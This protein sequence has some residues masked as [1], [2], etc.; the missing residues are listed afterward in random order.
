MPKKMVWV[1][2]G[3]PVL[4]SLL[5]LGACDDI[6]D[7]GV[8]G[9]EEITRPAMSVTEA[10]SIRHEEAEFFA[11]AEEIPG[12]GGY[13]F[14]E[15]GNLIAHIKDKTK[16]KED[17]AKKLLDSAL[18]KHSHALKQ[19]HGKVKIKTGEYAFPELA[20]WRDQLSEQLLGAGL[21]AHSTDADEGLNR[22]VVEVVSS[23]VR[24]TVRRKIAELGIPEGAVLVVEVDATGVEE[25]WVASRDSRPGYSHSDNTYAALRGG[26]PLYF[27]RDARLSYCTL[28]FFAKRS[29]GTL[30][31]VT[32]S[33]CSRDQW[34]G[35][36]DGTGYYADLDSNS[37]TGVTT[38]SSLVAW[39]IHDRGF[40]D[41]CPKLYNAIRW[42]RN[43]DANLSEVYSE[44]P[45]T[46]F[47]YIVR[48]ARIN[49][50][51]SDNSYYL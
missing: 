22:V 2:F 14:D 27:T 28:G 49:P 41:Y 30:V 51:S 15:E 42:C 12:F 8:L 36:G 19:K 39:E 10:K 38:L 33:H 9:P 1:S 35:P 23:G 25:P 4:A 34:D 44:A 17:K 24:E 20:A 48:Y 32:N 37:S 7:E 21:G 31:S 26:L 5:A 40:H 6:A 46:A 13:T 29:D 45:A 3:P 47:G 43:A 18:K 16:D 50:G 11:L